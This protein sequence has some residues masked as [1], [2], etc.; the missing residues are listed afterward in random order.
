M[1]GEDKL[2]EK[3]MLAYKISTL[4]VDSMASTSV[5]SELTTVPNP[6]VKR[7]INIIKE[8]KEDYIRLLPKLV[9][10]EKLLEL[11]A[12]IDEQKNENIN[13]NVHAHNEGL[14]SNFGER[15]EEIKELYEKT[16]SL[17]EEELSKTILNLQL[18]GLSMRKI[19]EATGVSLGRV[20]KIISN[21]KSK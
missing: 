20:H 9:T 7:Y 16:K 10:E 13:L 17:P 2:K 19:A 14:L 15:I 1:L 18:S 8:K 6:T 3:L 12:K 21:S 11:Q 4:Y 5:I